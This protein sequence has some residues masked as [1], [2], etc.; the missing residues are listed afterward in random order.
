MYSM[1]TYVD[2]THPHRYIGLHTHTQSFWKNVKKPLTLVILGSTIFIYFLPSAQFKLYHSI[3]YDSWKKSLTEPRRHQKTYS[4]LELANQNE[5]GV[6]SLYILK[7]FL[8][9]I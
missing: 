3:Y 4:T 2:K 1:S 8:S 9:I 7:M 5:N 6:P